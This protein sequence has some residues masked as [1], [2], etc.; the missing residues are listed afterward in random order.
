MFKVTDI[1]PEEGVSK[2]EILGFAACAQNLSNHPIAQSIKQAYMD[3]AHTRITFSEFEEFSGLGVRAV[4]DSKE[5]IAGNDK[6]LT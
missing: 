2:R 3:M 1:V 4:C 5:I 6:I